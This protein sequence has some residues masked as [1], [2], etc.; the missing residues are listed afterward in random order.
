MDEQGL[1]DSQIEAAVRAYLGRVARRYVPLV[2]GLVA[3]LLVVTLVPTVS[4]S[5]QSSQSA[6]AGLS[7]AGGGSLPGTSA[8]GAPSAGGQPASASA[9]VVPGAGGTNPTSGA[10]PGPGASTPGATSAGPSTATGPGTANPGASSGTAGAPVASG[11]A[12][13]AS[14][15]GR[16]TAPAGV[17][18]RGITPPAAPGSAGVAV[19]G[20][21][22][23]PGVRQVPWTAYAPLCVPAFH[24]NNGGATSHGVT[25]TT[26][27]LAYRLGSSA[28]DAAVAA[29]ASSANVNDPEYIQDLQTYI[30]FF[31]RQYEVYGRHVVLK[32][33]QATGDYIQEDQGQDQPQA[34][35]DA[36][37]ASQLGAF[38]DVTFDLKG[39]RPYWTALAQQHVVAF[40]PLGF[41]QSDYVQEA[42]YWYSYTPSGTKVG[43]LMVNMACQRMKGLPAIFAGDPL[44]Q[45]STRVFGLVTPDNPEYVEIGDEIQSGLAGCGVSLARR[46]TYSINV[47]TYQQE[48]ISLAAQLKAKGVT[49]VLC[50]CDPLI[51]IFLSDAAAGQ[52]YH[53]EWFQP[54]WGDPQ[55]RLMTQSEWDHHALASGGMYLPDNQNEAYRVFEL[56]D[57]GHPPADQYYAAAYEE[58]LQLFD[59]LQAAGPDLTPYSLERGL[60]SLPT[61][62]GQFGTWRSG[63]GAFTPAITSQLGWW[64]DQAKSNFDG[65]TGAYLNCE[66]GRFLPYSTAQA[67][68]WGPAHTQLHCFGQ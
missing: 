62:S 68:V 21:R 7:S 19:S 39:S 32:T 22:C 14:Q 63:N 28:Q 50:Y 54:Y 6:N 41:P 45:H 67:A 55:G 25:G 5:N 57:P 66:G 52:D 49:T 51:P 9:G 29:A 59:G 46:L 58:V 61:S 20:A 44:Y 3:F 18:G 12:G 34:Q 10:N 8:A 47:T 17:A 53:P 36:V 26:I 23:G 64:D 60:F 15:A 65:T 35:A 43:G 2:V 1:S 4:Q 37:T 56:A 40:G 33:F 24:G 38:A 16:A 13:S 27:T 11:G 30:G 31:N 48:G 42:P